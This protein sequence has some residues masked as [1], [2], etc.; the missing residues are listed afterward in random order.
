MQ[1][2]FIFL[3]WLI[4][5]CFFLLQDRA[6]KIKI[7]SRQLEEGE[8]T[9]SDFLNRISCPRNLLVPESVVS[10]SPDSAGNNSDSEDEEPSAPAVRV[11]A[12]VASR[13]CAVCLNAA[14]EFTFI[15]CGH[16][17]TC[18]TCWVEIESQHLRAVAARG[19]QDDEELAARC[20]LC[21]AVVTF[22]QKTYFA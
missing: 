13:K 15:P 5:L 10:D 2:Y 16:F 11:I 19:G 22:A 7:A 12:H 3:F 18:E 6:E 17:V 8:I 4:Q 1:V 14:P 21:R 20:P 9:A